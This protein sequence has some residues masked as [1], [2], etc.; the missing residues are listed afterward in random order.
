[1]SR[2]ESRSA[3]WPPACST[4]APKAP[5]PEVKPIEIHLSMP[6]GA[7]LPIGDLSTAYERVLR[8]D[9]R[10]ALEYGGNQGDLGLREWLANDFGR[11]ES[12][13]LAAENIVL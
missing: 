3:L 7:L 4:T 2:Q 11:K 8:T 1:M 10:R 6:D 12:T 5:T 9:G 13:L